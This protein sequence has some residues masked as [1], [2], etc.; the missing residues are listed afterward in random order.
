MNMKN[1]SLH[2][3]LD[4]I[5]ILMIIVDRGA[6]IIDRIRALIGKGDNNGGNK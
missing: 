2:Y 1:N 5:T 3:I 4:V 6:Y